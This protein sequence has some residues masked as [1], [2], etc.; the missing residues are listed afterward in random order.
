MLECSSGTEV[1]TQQTDGRWY[2]QVASG[3]ERVKSSPQHIV[4]LSSG[5][6]YSILAKVVG[7]R[8]YMVANQTWLAG[9]MS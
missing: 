3:P 5:R 2:V 1:P 8:T 4:M 9:E 6:M 7:A